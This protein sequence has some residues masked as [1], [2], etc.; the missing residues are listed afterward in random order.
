M[1]DLFAVF[2][3]KF[4]TIARTRIARSLD[5]ATERRPEH[6]PAIARE[7][8][9]IAGEAGLLGLGAIVSLARQ[10]EEHTRR[11]RSARSAE[12]ADALVAVLAELKDAVEHVAT[13]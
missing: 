13:P 7:L 2:M 11:L 5:L 12:E 8:H 9:A 1:N 10:G 4:L 3:P 6:V